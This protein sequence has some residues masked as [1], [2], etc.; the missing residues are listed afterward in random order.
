MLRQ[1]TKEEKNS[2]GEV[3]NYYLDKNHL[4]TRTYEMYKQAIMLS[5]AISGAGLYI[6]IA[7]NYANRIRGLYGDDTFAPIHYILGNCLGSLV[8]LYNSTDI[9]LTARDNEVVPSELSDVLDNPFSSEWARRTRDAVIVFFSALSS[10]PLSMIS[11]NYPAQ[12]MSPELIYTQ[13]VV[14]EI[15]N[16]LL[17]FLP[18]YLALQNPFFRLPVL[19]F[20]LMYR[21]CCYQQSQEEQ[22]RIDSNQVYSFLK[23]RLIAQLDAAQ[24]QIIF[25]H[26]VFKRGQVGPSIYLPPQL[27]AVIRGEADEDVENMESNRS[28]TAS[29]L[30]KLT[31]IMAYAKPHDPSKEEI[32]TETCSLLPPF[33]YGAGALLVTLSAIGYLAEPINAVTRWTGSKE[34]GWLLSFAPV[35]F[36]TILLIYFGGNSMQG[37]YHYLTSWGDDDVKM[38]LEFKL[39]SRTALLSMLATFYLSIFSYAGASEMIYTNFS[40]KQYD[41]FRPIFLFFAKAGITFLTFTA[42]TDFVRL[43]LGKFALH[44][45][46]D[47][48]K[49]MIQ[50]NTMINQMKAVGI[51]LM[52]GEKLIT[53]L[54]QL[55]DNQLSQFGINQKMFWDARNQLIIINDRRSPN[56]RRLS[57]FSR[58]H[59]P[60]V[61]REAATPI[62]PAGGRSS[63]CGCLSRL[64]NRFSRSKDNPAERPL[65]YG[66]DGT[67][68]VRAV[69]FKSQ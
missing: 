43:I 53:S 42:M 57:D 33:L 27:E 30:Q 41:D 55:N 54:E 11:I 21:Y 36:F 23:Q 37:T 8:V 28:S 19:P 47:K 51:P 12:W 29:T 45:G 67:T 5:V 50:L 32:T 17:H 49:M 48:E 38:P 46:N 9:F 15:D 18:I 58:E 22:N 2:L 6:V 66:S 13:A 63:Y 61:Q 14:T 31:T 35:Y 59:T 25:Q 56:H 39:Y 16:T 3:A 65:R 60:L 10:V 44:C 40:D 1:E 24:K 26:V 62:T 34:E 4:P 69:S 52:N 64:F 7:D 68:R 20:E